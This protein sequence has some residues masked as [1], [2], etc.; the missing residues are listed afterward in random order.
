[1]S[2]DKITKV[3]KIEPHHLKYINDSI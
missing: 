1:M 3:T 2:L